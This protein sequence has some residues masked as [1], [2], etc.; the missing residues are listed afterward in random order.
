MLN[1]ELWVGKKIEGGGGKIVILSTFTSTQIALFHGVKTKIKMET[2]G[3][4]FTL[5]FSLCSLV[6]KSRLRGP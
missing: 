3:T 4:V 6:L 1:K 5:F 2:N